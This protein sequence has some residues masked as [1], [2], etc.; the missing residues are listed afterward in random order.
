MVMVREGLSFSPPCIPVQNV[1]IKS[2]I[3]VRV[4]GRT[5]SKRCALVLDKKGCRGDR[6]ATFAVAGGAA[7]VDCDVDLFRVASESEIRGEG[8]WR[9]TWESE[10]LI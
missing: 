9:V 2:S 5:V 7:F 4:H 1:K 3:S 10:E 8:S 6:D